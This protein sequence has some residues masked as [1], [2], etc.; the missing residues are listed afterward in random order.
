[1]AKQ[2]PGD[3]PFGRAP[4]TPPAEPRR[5]RR[6]PRHRPPSRPRRRP[7]PGRPAGG[8]G[9]GGRAA[10]ARRSPAPKP[11]PGPRRGPGEARAAVHRQGRLAPRGAARRR[12]HARAA[13][14]GGAVPRS[15]APR[16]IGRAP[17]GTEAA[18]GF[19]SEF[20]MMERWVRDRLQPVLFER[21]QP[22]FS[23]PVEVVAP[24]RH[25]RP[26]RRRR[27]VRPRSGLRQEDR[28]AARFPLPLL[29]PRRGLGARER[30]LRRAR[31]DRR[32]PLGHAPLRR[33][34]ARCTPCAPSTRG[35]AT[36]GR[37]PRTSSSTSPTSAPLV[38]RLGG[39]RAC[40][41]NAERLLRQDQLIAVFPEGIKGIG[42]LYRERYQLQRFGRGGFVKLALRCDS[43]IIPAAIVG[44]EEIH[45]VLARFTWLAKNLGVPLPPHHADLPA[46]RARSASCRSRPSGSS[47]S[48]RRST[49]TPSTAPGP[50]TIASSSTASRRTC[51]RR[52]R[53]CSTAS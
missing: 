45:P 36:C 18:P 9:G 39:V 40:P 17:R 52:S 46:A 2:V 1:M 3:N 5:P 24:L 20:R 27:R 15:T 21:R 53:R 49:S 19:G 10:A 50:P 28:A 13:R 42:K 7:G 26:L 32:Q 22:P 35:T 38:N 12:G 44:A 29:L 41:E 4:A 6:R 14:R 23:L 37:S 34:H 30:P 16:S 51:A 47:A 31:A 33:H 8:Q 48:A 25:A 43:P 11:A